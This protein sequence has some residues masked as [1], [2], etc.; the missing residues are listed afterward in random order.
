MKWTKGATEGII[1]AGGNGQG[2]AMTH[3]CYPRG[4]W[5][6]GYGHVYVVDDGNHRMMR[7]EKDSKQG[8]VIVGGK[9]RGAQAN[10]LACAAGSVFDHRSDLYV[11]DCNNH[12][13]QRF[14][15]ITS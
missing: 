11:A 15:L 7:W 6:D 5:V 12:R 8:M 4:V 13:I 10:Q 2:E 14:S 9:E 1:V 3:L